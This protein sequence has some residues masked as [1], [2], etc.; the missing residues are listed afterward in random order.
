M[1]DNHVPVLLIHGEEDKFVPTW[2]SQANYDACPCKK[3]LL[4]VENAGHGSSVFENQE[5]YERTEKE[6]LEDV[7]GGV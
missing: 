1:K 3:K 5:L 6:F 2:M 7:L 4:F